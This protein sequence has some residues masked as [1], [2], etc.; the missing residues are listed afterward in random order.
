MIISTLGVPKR[1]TVPRKK[2]SSSAVIF[3]LIEKRCC[4]PPQNDSLLYLIRTLMGESWKPRKG[5]G[6]TQT[7]GNIKNSE[8]IHGQEPAAGNSA[9]G[10]DS[11]LYLASAGMTLLNLG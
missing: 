8:S 10:L 1:Q 7:G 3:V 11:G 2:D 9:V 5:D 4:W 6:I